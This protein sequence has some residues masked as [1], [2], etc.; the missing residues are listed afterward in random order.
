[1]AETTNTNNV[2]AAASN[3][4]VAQKKKAST[5]MDFVKLYKGEIARALPTAITPERFSRMVLTAITQTPKLK[6]CTPQS[7][8]GSMLTAAQLGLEPNTPLGQAYLIPFKNKGVMCCQFQLG[9]KGLIDLVHRSGEIASIEARVVYENDKFDYELGLEPK[10]VHKPAAIGRGKATWYYAIY[11]LKN[12]GY[13]FEVMSREDVEQHARKYSKSFGN[14]PWQT[15]FDEMAK[16][17]VLK[18]VLKYAPLKTEFVKGTVADERV[19]NFDETNS[20]IN[21]VPENVIEVDENGEVIDNET[22]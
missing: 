15:D 20:E 8:V 3:N 13:A 17:T 9:Y 7:F 22:R 2:I 18:K 11:H 16:K 6:E 4:A 12:G 5:I 1:M 14:G 19:N 10:L 21:I